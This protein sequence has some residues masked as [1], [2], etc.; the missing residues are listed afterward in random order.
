M[1]KLT[2]VKRG[3]M[4]SKYIKIAFLIITF[5]FSFGKVINPDNSEKS[6]K[7]NQYKYYELND[8]RGYSNLKDKLSLSDD[9]SVRV[10]IRLRAV[11]SGKGKS[12]K[13]FGAEIKINEYLKSIEFA[14]DGSKIEHKPGWVYTESGIWFLD[15]NLS[16]E[17]GFEIIPI[18]TKSGK[19]SKVSKNIFVRVTAEKL[20]RKEKSKKILDTVNKESK[21][22]INTK[23]KDKNKKTYWHFLGTDS[24]MDKSVDELQYAIKGPTNIRIFTRLNNF[25]L[26]Q[27][28]EDYI[29]HV[30]EDGLD[31]GSYFFKTNLSPVSRVNKTRSTVGKWRSCW[32]NVPSGTH[33]YTLRLEK[34]SDSSVFIRVKEYE[35]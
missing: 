21:Y 14:K 23:Q 2:K 28:E 34:S 1:N 3:K 12:L 25:D 31:I 16:S 19:I 15:M 4:Y 7:I 24:K 13:K 6:K 30:K 10:K 35:K 11:K 17:D 5:S 32:I 26:R 27:D 20:E 33:Y 9:D 8:G 22:I 18:K 29:L